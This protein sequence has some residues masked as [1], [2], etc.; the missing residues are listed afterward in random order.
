MYTILTKVKI[1]D[2]IYNHDIVNNK[3]WSDIYDEDNHIQSTIK[4]FEN[5]AI[6]VWMTIIL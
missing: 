6:K 5:I 4:V 3:I 1:E 2:L